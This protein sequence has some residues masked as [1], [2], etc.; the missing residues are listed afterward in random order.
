MKRIFLCVT[1]VFF[2]TY[3]LSSDGSAIR[4]DNP[5][6]YNVYFDGVQKINKKSSDIVTLY[7]E[8]GTLSGGFDIWYEIPLSG[9]VPLYVKGDHRTIR[10]SQTSLTINEPHITENYGRYIT[11]HNSADNAITFRTS[12]TVNPL[13]EQRGTPSSENYLIPSNKREFSPGET[14]VFNITNDSGRESFYIHDS[15]RDVPLTLPL[16]LKRNYLYAYTYTPSGVTLTDVRPLH[17]IG[18]DAWAKTINNAAEPMQ[19]VTADGE[20]HLFVSTNK[21]LI[22]NVYDSAGNV[23]STIQSGD[24]FNITYASKAGDGFF[25]AGYERLPNGNY[26]PV[27]RIQN[28]DGST[29]YVLKSSEEYR[30]ARFFTAAQKDNTTWL[31]AGDGVKAG[32]YGNTA[33]ARMVRVINDELIMVWELSP[34]IKCGEIKSAVYDNARNCWFVTGENLEFDTMKNRIAGSYIAQIS[35][36]GTIQKIDYSFKDMS[37]NRI[38]I[39]VNG[40]CYLAGEEYI[41][42][43]TCAVLGKYTVNQHDSNF[44]RILTQPSHSYY[45]DALLDTANNQIIL[46]GVLK[47][48]DETGRG[49]IPFIDAIDIQTGTLSWHE[50]LSSTEIKGAVVVTAIAPAPDYGFAL[51]LS[52]IGNTTG[53]YEEPYMI[54]RVNSQGKYIKEIRQ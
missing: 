43:E 21:G 27:A 53:Y 32:F 47:A 35:G 12:G 37:F 2:S 15:G 26:R 13:M 45:E 30:T 31:L 29:R 20:I 28:V 22:R 49:G 46:G 54:V 48:K 11:I 5:T 38:L 52:G 10:E 6:C 51:T 7:I 25:I 41:G 39:D 19:L 8:S 4:V 36:D 50:E 9:T 23:R 34:E 1:F 24:A 14:G 3:V 18:E 33:Y 42:N 40:I 16:P 17:R 44:Q